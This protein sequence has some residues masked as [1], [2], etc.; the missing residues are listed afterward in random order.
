MR[1]AD[2]MSPWLFCG[3]EIEVRSHAIINACE[4]RG[5]GAPGGIRMHV[6]RPRFL[7]K[8]TGLAV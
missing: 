3:P 4:P 2:R 8:G 1:A 7:F 6:A 5:Q